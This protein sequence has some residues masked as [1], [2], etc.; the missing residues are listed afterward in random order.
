[1]VQVGVLFRANLGRA[2]FACPGRPALAGGART[3]KA[4]SRA[5]RGGGRGRP[6]GG[7]EVVDV[8]VCAEVESVSQ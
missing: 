5:G 8:G 1:M 3:G 6:H 4:A 2:I 7:V